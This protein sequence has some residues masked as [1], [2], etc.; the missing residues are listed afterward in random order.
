[1]PA[2]LVDR[3]DVGMIQLGDGLGLVLKPQQ[4]GLRR[5]AARLDQLEGDVPVECD[6]QGLVNHPH[7]APPQLVEDIIAGRGQAVGPAGTEPG[8]WC[9]R[10]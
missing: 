9:C 4:L 3:D 5:D 6:L 1:M 8:L 2:D 7:P 10:H